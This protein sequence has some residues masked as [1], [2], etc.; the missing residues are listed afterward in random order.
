MEPRIEADP[1]QLALLSRE[2]SDAANE[3]RAHVDRFRVN[4]DLR[5]DEYGD[6]AASGEA[7]TA[8]HET[9]DV[10]AAYLV[11]LRDE[12]DRLAADLATAARAQ[13]RTLED[14]NSSA[15]QLHQV[16]QD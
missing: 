13:Q 9:A 1:A 15:R 7:A 16:I 12:I 2:F 11:D 3:L 4:G 14:A 5:G 10:A 8:D 6:L